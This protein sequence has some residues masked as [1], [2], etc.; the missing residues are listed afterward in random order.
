ME[1]YYSR[2]QEI[3]VEQQSAQRKE[4]GIEHTKLKITEELGRF[5]IHSNR[6]EDIWVI[7]LKWPYPI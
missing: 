7:G 4:I 2:L 1:H 3:E 6:V 5:L